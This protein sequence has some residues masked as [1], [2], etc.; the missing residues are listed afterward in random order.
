[1]KVHVPAPARRLWRW[2]TSMRT[3][4]LL[5]L[6][7]AI[8][9]VPGSILPQR[10]VRAEDVAAYLRDH[11]GTGAWFDRFRLFD[12]Y[13]SP[14]FSAIYL[15][16]FIS[17][18]GCLL[19][20]LRQHIG[21]IVA[22]PPPA[23]ARFERLPRSRTG[24]TRGGAPDAVGVEVAATLKA[25][26]WRTKVRS[27]DD[28]S[29]TV[30]GEKGYIK[31]TG[32]LVF[33]FALLTLLIGVALGSWYGWHG[34]RLLVAGNEGFCN[35]LPNYD[36]YGLGARTRPEDLPPFCVRLDSFTAKY[37]DNG[38]PIQY[39]A[40]VTYSDGLQGTDEPWRLEVNDPLRLHGSNVY[41]LGHGYAPILRY[42]DRYGRTQTQVTPFLPVDGMQTSQG[43]VKF[44]DA[45]VD[46]TGKT[47]RDNSTQVAFV[48]LYLPT[49]AAT[50]DGSLSVFPA[51]RNPGLQ[52]TA[53]QGDIGL[54]NG[55]PQSVYTLDPRQI[56]TGRL[57]QV[58]QTK[59][60]K[61]GETWQLP[62]GTSVQ[63]V[64]TQQ[65]ITISV[66][67][68]PGEKVVLFG[69]GA[70]LVG[71]MVSLT[72][73][74][75]RVW[76]RVTPGDGGSSLISL[77]GLARNDYT[78][79]GEEFDRLAALVATPTHDARQPVAVGEKGP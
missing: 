43:A 72:G 73:R 37:L 49:M 58:A 44:P 39:T 68:D 23:P 25:Q 71:L 70:L 55:R 62:D 1:M 19:P 5:L 75:R 12:V 2:L 67:H 30:S 3:A 77:G 66:R 29:V 22:A 63:F 34:N 26:R 42:T 15:L 21:N 14:W 40:Q 28:G 78:G 61:P 76:A 6:L 50:V 51:E 9:A 38:Q 47:P 11:P 4:L 74:R 17:L 65:W 52:L 20:R 33:H 64:G 57:K 8:A 13:S 35:S 16:L 41:L 24:L 46:P 32:N 10:G 69:A 56:S 36:E 18:V 59:A 45:N 79:F 53:Y 48:G 27:H 7:L 60:L 31:E 54:G